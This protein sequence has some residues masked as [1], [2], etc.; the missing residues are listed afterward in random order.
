MDQP[1]AQPSRPVPPAPAGPLGHR[2]RRGWR[3]T[4]WTALAVATAAV[5]VAAA[6]F[7]RPTPVKLG[8]AHLGQAIDVV[9]ASGVVEYVRQAH[10]APVTTAPIRQVAAAE[11]DLVARGALLA[12]LDDGPQR[13]TALQLEA[14]AAMA[15]A[16][17]AR[18]QRLL[19]A[20][21]GARAAN[22]DAQAQRRA[23]EGAAQSAWARL[24]DYRLVAPLAGRVLRRDAEPGDLAVAG[25]TLFLIADPGAIRV[26]ADV[27]ERDVGRLKVGQLALVRADAFIDQT[28]NARVAQITPAGNATGRVFRV[29]LALPASTPLAPGMTVETNLITARRDQAVLVPSSAVRDAAVW[30]VE[31]GRAHRHAVRLGASAAS[32]TEITSG[33]PAGAQV[34]LDPPAG[35]RE[36]ARVRPAQGR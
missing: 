34:V 2:P 31:A 6:W 18:T 19:D 33:L 28:F 25:T 1:T 36:G 22:D 7:L 14:Q 8:Q 13:G 20:G 16:G 24:A 27:D 5:A 35:L 23:A 15:R 10:V 3:V 9:Y 11:G 17:A 21:F 4:R 12:Q 32:Q 30:S 26:T 29:R